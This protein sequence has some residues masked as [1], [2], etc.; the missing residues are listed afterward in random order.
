[1]E[2]YSAIKKNEILSFVMRWLELD[3]IML[4]KVSRGQ[5]QIPHDFTHV[6][7]KNKTDEIGEGKRER[8]RQ[9]SYEI[10]LMS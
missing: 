5:N 2:Y 9:I 8:G 3:G 1:M 10:C 4:R 7:F 6:E